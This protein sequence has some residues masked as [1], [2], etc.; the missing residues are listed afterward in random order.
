MRKTLS[1][2]TLSIA[3]L[4]LVAAC[5]TTE[6]DTIAA[7]DCSAVNWNGLGFEDGIRG[8]DSDQFSAR[9]NVCGDSDIQLRRDRYMAGYDEGVARFCTAE[10]GYNQGMTGYVYTGICPI[11]M[12]EAFVKALHAGHR[13]AQKQTVA[14]RS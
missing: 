9:N 3:A 13:A 7:T 11:S 14:G 6:P 4:S 5:S 1:I 10:N 8:L 12:E 2:T